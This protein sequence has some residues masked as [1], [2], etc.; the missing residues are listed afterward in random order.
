V[1][2]IQ[3]TSGSNFAWSGVVVEIQPTRLALHSRT[4][5]GNIETIDF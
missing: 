5:L 4:G 2:S 1:D 3:S